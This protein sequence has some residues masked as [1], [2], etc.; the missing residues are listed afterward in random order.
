MEK[1]SELVDIAKKYLGSDPRVKF[2]VGKGEDVILNAE[3]KSVD[4]IFADTWP[5]K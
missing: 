4:F 5:G 3:P 1:N 2:I